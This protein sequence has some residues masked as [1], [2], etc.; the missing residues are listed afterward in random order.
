MK[1][2]I[3]IRDIAQLVAKLLVMNA[4]ASKKDFPSN[5]KTNL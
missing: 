3:D 4:T 1:L 2:V 5:E